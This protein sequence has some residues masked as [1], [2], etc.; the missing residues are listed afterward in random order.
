MIWSS[1]PF[2]KVSIFL[3]FKSAYVTFSQ[4]KESQKRKSRLDSLI[5]H[6]LLVKTKHKNLFCYPDRNK[7]P[8]CCSF[9]K[10]VQL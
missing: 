1:P 3:H 8:E 2:D 4:K 6:S 10:S 7:F 9:R 5:I